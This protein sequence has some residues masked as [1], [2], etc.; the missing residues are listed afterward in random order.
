MADRADRVEKQCLQAQQE[1][2]QTGLGQSSLT[3]RRM[4]NPAGGRGVSPLEPEG[5]ELP[6]PEELCNQQESNCKAKGKVARTPGHT[7]GHAAP[8]AV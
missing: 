3:L 5:L 2:T 6:V 8:K 7:D 1:G 4:Q